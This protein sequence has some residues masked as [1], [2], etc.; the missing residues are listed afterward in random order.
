MSALHWPTECSRG[1]L[2]CQ[3]CP[4]VSDS[5]DTSSVSKSASS[6]FAITS[7]VKSFLAMT[8]TADSPIKVTA[9]SDAPA[10]SSIFCV[11]DPTHD[12]QVIPE[13]ERD[14]RPGET[15]HRRF[16]SLRDSGVDLT[17][18]ETLELDLNEIA[19]SSALANLSPPFCAV[20]H[21]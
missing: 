6:T 11:T 10:T 14:V 15:N 17:A 1:S 5:D 19:D 9:I 16:R 2:N 7:F 12:A 18:S 3:T 4:S 20:R 13:I 21:S 8:T